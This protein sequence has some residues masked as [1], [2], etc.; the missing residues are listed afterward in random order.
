MR[1]S[2]S[3]P[4]SPTTCANRSR[5]VL[6]RLEAARSDTSTDGPQEVIDATIVDLESVLETFN[7]L[8]RIGQ[9]EAGARRA[10][11][12]AL[13]L[14]DI[15]R[16]VVDAFEPAAAEEGKALSARFEAPLPILGDRELLVQMIANL[17][18]NALQAQPAGRPDRG[19]RFENRSRRRADGR[20]RR[21][22]SRVRRTD[23][24]FSALLSRRTGARR[25]GNRAWPC[26]RRSDRRT[27]RARVHGL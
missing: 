9:I 21:S 15:T 25:A 2:R 3:A 18:D 12:Q 27:A 20:R 23:Q 4:I 10:A 5:G 8:L 26:A 6:R 1:T 13:D 24:N 22:G 16:E 19:G 14:A 17:I 7:A 11:F